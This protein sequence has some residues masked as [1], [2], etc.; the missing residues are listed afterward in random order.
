MPFRD[1]SDLNFPEY[2]SKIKEPIALDVIKE[3][4]DKGNPDQ[5]NT[6]AT[7]TVQVFHVKAKV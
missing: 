2:T 5:V 1:C 4:L 7:V 6:N 3:R